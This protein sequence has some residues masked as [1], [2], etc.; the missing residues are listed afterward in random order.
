MGEL[1]ALYTV[2]ISSLLLHCGYSIQPHF[3]SG[4]TTMK[5]HPQ[6]VI[7]ISEQVIADL[8]RM[9]KISVHDDRMLVGLVENVI[10]DELEQEEKLDAEVR[11]ILAQHYEEMRRSGVSYDEMFRKVKH[12][13][14]KEKGIVL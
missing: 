3:G 12:K 10:N 5:L 11:G 14:A 4:I 6:V 9:H 8:V 1:S 13:L 2:D 7:Y